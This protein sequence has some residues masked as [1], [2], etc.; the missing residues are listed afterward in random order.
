[1]MRWPDASDAARCERVQ[2][3]RWSYP[4]AALPR[5]DGVVQSRDC[6]KGRRPSFTEAAPPDLAERL[7]RDFVEAMCG[8]GVEVETGTFQA[9]MLVEINNDGP[10]TLI[11]ER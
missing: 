10:V 8:E 5:A 6:E 7:Y 1:M 11:L 2:T 9:K 4:A 3:G